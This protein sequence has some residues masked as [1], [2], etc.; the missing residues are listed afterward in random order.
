MKY[1]TTPSIP[2]ND[3][4]TVVDELQRIGAS[5][6]EPEPD[7]MIFKV[8]AEEPPRPAQGMLAFADGIN[9]NPN[10]DGVGL[11]SYSGT[12]WFPLASSGSSTITDHTQLTSIGVYTHANIDTHINDAD[13]HI[14]LGGSVGQVITNTGSG[15]GSWQAAGV[16]EAPIDGVEYI[17]KN[18]A[19]ATVPSGVTDHGQLTSI[20]VNTHAQIDAFIA[21]GGTFDF[22]AD[23]TYTGLNTFN[24]FGTGGLT[25]YDIS[26]G[27][28]D[29]T[30]TYG[31]A[32]LGDSII[33][34]TSSFSGGYNLNGAFICQNIGGSIAGD[35]EYAFLDDTNLIRFALPTSTAGNATY[36]PRSLL[37]THAHY[38]VLALL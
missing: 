34:R 22:A 25:D 15:T 27:D 21:S 17:R 26:I 37:C 31:M 11:Y 1:A 7:V 28:T 24:N 6:L 8:W 10:G 32:R 30:P 5:L 35:I 23:H 20:G 29:G 2:A 33:G 14:P 4:T 16:E 13:R 38:C 19:W 36:N 12:G 18:A 3:E 9:W